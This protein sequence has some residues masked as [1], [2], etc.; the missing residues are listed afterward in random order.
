MAIKK[1]IVLREFQTLGYEDAKAGNELLGRSEWEEIRDYVLNNPDKDGRRVMDVRA[2]TIKAKNYV[3]VLQTSKGTTIEILPK[4][5]LDVGENETLEKEIFLR[6][7][8]R[9]RDGP[10]RS[11]NNA[12][13]RALKNFPLLE[14]F[15]G[16]FLKDVHEL[17]RR[18]LACAYN[19]IQENRHTL[20]GKLL[21]AKNLRHN[22]IH[23]ERFYVQYQEFSANRPI[24]RLLKSTL[25]LLQRL[26]RSETNRSHIRQARLYFEDI[27]AS[28][29]VD[30]DLVRARVDRTMPLYN[31]LFPWARLF[32]K[33]ASPTTWKDR[34]PALA[35]LFPMERIF[36]DYVAHLVRMAATDTDWEVKTQ[37][38]RNHLIEQN[39]KSK[40]EF[41][42][43]P[44]VVTRRNA[45]K[46]CEVRVMDTKWKRLSGED[47]KHH[48]ISQ[49]DLYQMYAYGKKYHAKESAAPAL[50]LLYPRN[51]NFKEQLEYKYETGLRLTVFPVDLRE[52]EPLYELLTPLNAA[53]VK[54]A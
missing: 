43:R 5:E 20:K 39:P 18:G 50:Y 16:M 53:R 4:V 35:L 52:E 13:V 31:R 12:D 25:L 54:A 22:L 27:P 32:L 11:F 37:E 48:D 51:K 47:K 26:S 42:L 8:R 7:L 23:K 38:S 41:R 44:D 17:T 46:H 36:E 6:M 10:F 40:P 49:S 14:A 15:I 21:I 2:K 33:R 3:G 19:E 45:G 28:A 29:D 1:T 30:A 24:N 9:W 34:N